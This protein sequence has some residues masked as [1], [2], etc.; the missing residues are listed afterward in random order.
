MER[1]CRECGRTVHVSCTPEQ[2]AKWQQGELIQ[3]AMP[4]VSVDEREILISG[5]CGA[6]FDEITKETDE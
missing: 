1:T 5:Y 4:N 3:R 2:Y 6:C